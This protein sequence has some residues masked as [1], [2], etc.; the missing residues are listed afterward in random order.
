MAKM[1]FEAKL[2]NLEPMIDFILSAAKGSGFGK[3]EL[4]QIRLASEEALVNVIHYAYPNKEGEV[5]IECLNN[6][7]EG[8][9]VRI[10]D[11]GTPFNPLESPAPDINSPLQQRK[12]GGLGVHLIRKMM[13]EVKYKREQDSNILIL[14]KFKGK[15]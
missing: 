13:D 6:V 3:K 10:I 12:I 8:L 7:S 2:E 15:D 5:E 1:V 11:R 4:S 9:E 14:I